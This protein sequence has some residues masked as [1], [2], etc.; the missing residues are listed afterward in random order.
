MTITY[1]D[2]P[3]DVA[4][5]AS[6]RRVLAA[7]QAA[8]GPLGVNAICAQVGLHANT[9]RFHL[10]ALVKQQLVERATEPRQGPGRPRALY[11]SITEGTAGG[12]RRYG[13]LA[14]MLVEYV[15]NQSERPAAAALEAGE[16]WGRSAARADAESNTTV[17]AVR[18]LVDVLGDYGFAPEPVDVG[19]RQQILLH[20][21]PFREAAESNRDVVCALHLGLMRGVLAELGAPVEAETIDPFVTPNLC[22]ARL[23]SGPTTPRGSNG[24]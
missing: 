5:G 8:D 12:A 15:A 7:L 13:L 18:Q 11:K 21:C 16:A 22:I 17:G 23:G 6:R 4:I 1:A 2:S 24:Q 9:A 10:D 20:H 14:Q 19:D 3:D